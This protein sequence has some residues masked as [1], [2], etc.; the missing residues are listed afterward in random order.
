MYT[1]NHIARPNIGMLGM[2]PLRAVLEF[3]R[4]QFIPSAPQATPGDGHAV[5]LFPG[6]GTDRHYMKPLARHCERLGYVAY[7]WGRGRNV[8]PKGPVGPWIG[9]LAKEMEAMLSRHP[10]ATFIGW[11]LGGIYAR[12]L[13]KA[14]PGR[15]R[16]VITLGSPFS[17]INDST[18]VGW[19][20]ELLTGS[21]TR[22]SRDFARSLRTPPPVPNTS[23]YSRSDG[24]VAWKACVGDAYANSENIEVASSHLGLVWHPEVFRIVADRLAQPRGQWAPFLGNVA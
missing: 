16:Q 11:S 7:D 20:Y 3:A 10:D 4:L 1:P 24:V 23:I 21:S 22:I 12:E 15:V 2:E 18:N 6:L 9:H 8:G 14:M 5:V 17:R 19:L 13:A